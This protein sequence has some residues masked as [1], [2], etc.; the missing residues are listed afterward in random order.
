M[1]DKNKDLTEQDYLRKHLEEKENIR[2]VNNT[3]TY[4]QPTQSNIDTTRATDLGFFAYDVKEFPCGLFYPLGTTIQIKPATV[5]EIQSYSMVDDENLADVFEKMNDMLSSCIR[6][7][8]ADGTIGSYMDLKDQDRFYAIFVIREMT[9]Q[10]NTSLS[11]KVSCSCGTENVI[12]YKRANFKHFKIDPKIEKY[13]DKSTSSFRFEI[14]NGN[15]FNLGVPS[16]GL[17]KSFTEYIMKEYEQKRKPK[18]SFVKIMPF[19][20]YD[21]K[22]ITIEGIQ[23]KI[24]EFEKM[25]DISFQFLNS[26]VSKMTFGIEKISKYCDTCGLEVHTPFSFPNGAAAI[27]VIPDAFDKY[28]L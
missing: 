26:A 2:N 7:K 27:F 9:F 10:Q 1:S 14:S 11:N 25:D 15:V 19:L 18:I 8:Y 12:E 23:K 4:N 24:E 21:R 22:N 6:V 17:G 13:F 5:K 16:I 3:N 28:I 20:L